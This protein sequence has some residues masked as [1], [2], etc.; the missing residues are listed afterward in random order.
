MSF[1]AKIGCAP[2]TLKDWVNKAA[3][4]RGKRANVSCEMAEKMEDWNARTE[5]CAR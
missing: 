5:N 2:Q 1:S 4:N 3:V